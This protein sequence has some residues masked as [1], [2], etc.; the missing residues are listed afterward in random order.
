[1]FGGRAAGKT[2]LPVSMMNAANRL[3]VSG[4]YELSVLPTAPDAHVLDAT[5]SARPLMLNAVDVLR[6][7]SAAGKRT[8]EGRRL[9]MTASRP[10]GK[11]VRF[12]RCANG[13][14]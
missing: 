5:P 4:G 13:L 2:T 7:L 14:V 12:V 9:A 3:L 1:M 10:S 8:P 6:E 11:R